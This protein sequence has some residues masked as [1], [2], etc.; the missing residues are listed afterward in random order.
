VSSGKVT[1]EVIKKYIES[2]NEE[3]NEDFKVDGE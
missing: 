3:E 2:Q 1:D